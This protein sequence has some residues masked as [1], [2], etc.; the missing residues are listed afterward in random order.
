M[1]SSGF[2]RPEKKETG[3]NH[4]EKFSDREAD[5]ELKRFVDFTESDLA[6]EFMRS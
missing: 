5:E 4:G 6:R 1:S 3:Q 2:W